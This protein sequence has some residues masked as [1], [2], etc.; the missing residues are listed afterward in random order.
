LTANM[1]AT[2]AVVAALMLV[3]ST[4]AVPARVLNQKFVTSPRD[5]LI[6]THLNKCN[7][8]DES[9]INGPYP[10]THT[11]PEFGDRISLLLFCTPDSHVRAKVNRLHYR[12]DIEA[13][14]C[15]GDGTRKERQA[16][17]SCPGGAYE[18]DFFAKSLDEQLDCYPEETRAL[19]PAED[20]E[21]DFICPAVG[22][23]TMFVWDYQQKV[24]FSAPDADAFYVTC[25]GCIAPPPRNDRGRLRFAMFNRH[26]EQSPSVLLRPTTKRSVEDV[27]DGF[28]T[29]RVANVDKSISTRGT[30]TDVVVR[31]IASAHH[32]SFDETLSTLAVSATAIDGGFDVTIPRLAPGVDAVIAFR[33]ASIK[34][35]VATLRSFNGR[36]DSQFIEGFAENTGSDIEATFKA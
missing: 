9:R 12:L 11:D 16:G 3:S 1:L 19:L 7:V 15:E 36:S 21:F 6:G 30:L 17:F 35:V 26:P 18:D 25:E 28:F 29:V 13:I 20:P 2:L 10:V 4:A 23:L 27:V 8:E 32:F 33:H 5:T 24:D 22:V 14:L 34:S 31:I